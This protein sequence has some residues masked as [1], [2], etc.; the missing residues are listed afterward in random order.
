MFEPTDS[1]RGAASVILN[2]PGYRVDAVD[3]SLDQRRVTVEPVELEGGCPDCGVVSCRVHAWTRQR[4]RDVPYAGPAEVVGPQAAA[5]VRRARVSAA[6]L[7][8][9]HEPAAVAGAVADGDVG[10]GDRLRPG[11]GGGGR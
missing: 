2:L 9:Q 4:V 7:H 1:Q 6:D 11:G 8:P 10:R 5:G 3:L